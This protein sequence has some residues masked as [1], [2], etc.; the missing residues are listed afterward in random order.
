MLRA[1]SALRCCA[2][3]E[4][5]LCHHMSIECIMNVVHVLKTQLAWVSRDSL[6]VYGGVIKAVATW[7]H[8]MNRPIGMLSAEIIDEERSFGVL[9]MYSGQQGPLTGL[10]RVA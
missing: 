5:A 7:E 9:Y 10:F 3:H 6:G 8:L 4:G 1:Q 2:G